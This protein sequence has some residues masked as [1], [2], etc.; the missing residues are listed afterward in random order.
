MS[1]I[2]PRMIQ[3]RSEGIQTMTE[4]KEGC[5]KV[6]EEIRRSDD[7]PTRS[8]IQEYRLG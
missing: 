8:E 7:D 5:P 2:D 3:S 6:T 1:Q 4:A